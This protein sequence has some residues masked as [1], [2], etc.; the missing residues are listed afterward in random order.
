MGR[1]LIVLVTLITMPRQRLVRLS[2]NLGMGKLCLSSSNNS[3]FWSFCRGLV[4]ITAFFVA[5][6]LGLTE[7]R[8][9]E[10]KQMEGL[11]R[12][13]GIGGD[14][15]KWIIGTNSVGNSGDGGVFHWEGGSA[16]WKEVGGGG[17]FIAVDE[18]GIPWVVNTDNH[19]WK[20]DKNTQLW[21][22]V[23]G[24][25]R[26]IG[27]GARGGPLGSAPVWVIGTNSVG[28][29]GDSGV[30]KFDPN[31]P[32]TWI[33]FPGGGGGI[34]I[35]VDKGGN[36]WVVNT[37]GQIS[38]A[39]HGNW[40][41]VPG[42]ARDI[43]IGGPDD[44]VWI[45]GTNSVGNSG[46]SGVFRWFPDKG[47]WQECGGGGIRIAVDVNGLPWIVNSQGQIWQRLTECPQPQ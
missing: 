22:G 24:L 1:I 4:P 9:E 6:F 32:D 43:S 42:L 37:A 28:N 46:D 13:I 7:S 30:F 34:W 45:I 10:W 29:S 19:I 3:V 27:I 15:S 21:T 25:A 35:A 11:A 5:S 33:P 41:P 36:P 18:A 2:T 38:K 47:K 14:G 16:P 12:D 26:D 39:V 8:A 44:A 23:P 20:F 17:A 31:R 40:V